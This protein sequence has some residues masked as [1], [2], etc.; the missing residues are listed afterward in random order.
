MLV[1]TP[2]I[3]PNAA[4]EIHLF[5]PSVADVAKVGKGKSD[6]THTSRISKFDPTFRV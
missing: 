3:R 2:A 1:R 4:A 5:M 6:I